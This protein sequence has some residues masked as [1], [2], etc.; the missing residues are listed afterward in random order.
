M[1]MTKGENNESGNEPAATL[2]ALSAPT[3]PGGVSSP[4]N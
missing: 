4:R 1:I 3:E 2:K